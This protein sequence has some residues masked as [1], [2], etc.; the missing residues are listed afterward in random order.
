MLCLRSPPN[1]RLL[2]KCIYTTTNC[3]THERK[4]VIDFCEVVEMVELKKSVKEESVKVVVRCRPLSKKEIE[5]GHKSIIKMHYREEPTKDFT[6]DA[7]YDEK[8]TQVELYDEVFRDLVDSVLSGYNATIFAYG[9]TGTGKTHTMEGKCD[10][11][12]Q[13]GVIYRCIDHIFDHIG[14][15]RNQKYLV[16]A[17][18]LEIYQEELRDL[19]NTEGSKKLEIKEKPDG[20][21]YVKDLSAFVSESAESIQKVMATGNAQRS[22]GRT[23]MNEH[24]SRSHAIFIITVECSQVGIDGEMHITVGR[25]NLVDLAGSERQAKTGATGER[26]KEATKINLSLSALGNVIS[27]LVDS[28]SSH[29]PYRDSKL[30]RLLQDSLGGNSKTVMVAC[31]GPAS[32]NYEETLGTLRYANRAKNIKNEPKINEDPK[33]ALLREFQEEIQRLRSQLER[34]KTKSRGEMHDYDEQQRQLAN[35]RERLISN[36]SLVR[37][38]KERL[39]AEL[40]RK[41]SLLEKER[42]EQNRVAEMIAN[43]ESRIIGG[44]GNEQLQQRTQQQQEQ[45][46]TKRRELSE[47]K[48]REREMAEQLERQEEDALDL[49][50][51]FSDLRQEVEAK[52]KKLKKLIFKLRQVRSEIRDSTAIFSDER[53]DLDQ[54]ISEISKELKLK[55]LVVENFIPP[56]VGERIKERAVWSE[57]DSCW[58]VPG[59]RPLSSSTR[60]SASSSLIVG[61]ADGGVLTRSTGAD[62]GVSVG[63][64]TSSSTSYL[65]KRPTST[66]GVRRPISMCERIYVEKARQQLSGERRPPI[67]GTSAFVEPILPEETIRFC[68]ENVV[69][70]SGLERFQPDVSTSDPDSSSTTS[71]DAEENLMI[72]ASKVAATSLST[73]IRS[74]SGDLTRHRR[75][76]E[77]ITYNSSKPVTSTI[78]KTNAT[79][80]KSDLTESSDSEGICADY[81][82][83]SGGTVSGFETSSYFSNDLDRSFRQASR[84]SSPRNS[85]YPL[86]L[87]TSCTYTPPRKTRIPGIMSKSFS[88]TCSSKTMGETCGSRERLCEDVGNTF[89]DSKS[90]LQRSR[91]RKKC[92]ASSF[93]PRCLFAL[94]T[95]TYMSMTS[96]RFETPKIKPRLLNRPQWVRHLPSTSRSVPPMAFS[97]YSARPLD[98]HDETKPKR[99]NFYCRTRRNSEGGLVKLKPVHVARLG[100]LRCSR[101]RKCRDRNRL[102]HLAIPSRKILKPRRICKPNTTRRSLCS[103]RRSKGR[104]SLPPKP[105][106]PFDLDWAL[107]F[108]FVAFVFRILLFF[109]ESHFPF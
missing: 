76:I 97:Q 9:Q 53:Q 105:S 56:E 20:G 1:L 66:A 82:S 91:Q 96:S 89:V 37:Q 5:N 32:Y 17:S 10:L 69:V 8:S 54:S 103:C 13:R 52:T 102:S 61:K 78:F 99:F 80:E 40:E 31:I 74:P 23:N 95:S 51:T 62:S 100:R 38:E 65:D 18:Y 39:M 57:D 93:D 19:L 75:N 28:K 107:F 77:Q 24:S 70:F 68:G 67:S 29:V 59:V 26:F 92:R 64:S 79:F 94:T 6:F 63:D 34:R 22:V 21:V 108:A 85:L 30:T 41:S 88:A 42:Q 87:S 15:S 35:D 43:I 27:A 72:D 86:S 12:E 33:D 101:C 71:R 49:R 25:L 45:L 44:H 106:I 50:Q 36:G 58:K 60:L 48:K 3:S 83:K 2:N 109:S 73:R 16:R 81:G 46:E 90:L 98:H 104:S 14:S 47:Q 4:Q 84:R 7:I 55:L 11:D